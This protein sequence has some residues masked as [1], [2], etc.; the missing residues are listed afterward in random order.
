MSGGKWIWTNRAFLLNV[1]PAYLSFFTLGLLSP[2]VVQFSNLQLTASACDANATSLNP[3]TGLW[4]G[5]TTTARLAVY[6]QLRAALA[7]LAGTLV[8]VEKEHV[9]SFF[10]F[11]PVH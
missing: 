6:A 8:L 5:E 2:T 7:P 1:E 4:E 10:D 9:P 3:A 11:L